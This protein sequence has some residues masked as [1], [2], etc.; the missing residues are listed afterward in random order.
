VCVILRACVW[1]FVVQK[2]MLTTVDHMRNWPM[3]LISPATGFISSPLLAEISHLN[4]DNLIAVGSL[5]SG[6]SGDT[7]TSSRVLLVP[8][9]SPLWAEVCNMRARIASAGGEHSR[10]LF[11]HACPSGPARYADVAAS[12]AADALERRLCG[13]VE[14]GEMLML[15]VP[16]EE[17]G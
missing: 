17:S 7:L 14:D 11:V 15:C 12:A 3:A 16:V 6:L 4:Q 2:E 8:P 10:H 9:K 1:V 13:P 5:E